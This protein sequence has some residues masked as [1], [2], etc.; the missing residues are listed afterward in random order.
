MAEQWTGTNNI[1]KKIIPSDQ[2]G[3]ASSTLGLGML[4]APFFM[5][6]LPLKY[7]SF[8][9][10]SLLRPPLSPFLRLSRSLLSLLPSPCYEAPIYQLI[11]AFPGIVPTVSDAREKE[12]ERKLVSNRGRRSERERKG[13]GD[14]SLSRWK[15]GKKRINNNGVLKKERRRAEESATD[16]VVTETW[17]NYNVNWPRLSHIHANQSD[18]HNYLY[19]HALSLCAKNRNILSSTQKSTNCHKLWLTHTET[20]MHPHMFLYSADFFTFIYLF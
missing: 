13:E 12:N 15:D 16:I 4:R 8:R 20:Q 18:S 2:R 5:R 10:E 6:K 19:S 3:S 11:A 9:C 14:G 7:G 17:L 1:R